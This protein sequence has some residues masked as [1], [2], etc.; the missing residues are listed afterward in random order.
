MKVDTGWLLTS[1]QTWS[2]ADTDEHRKEKGGKERK[3]KMKRQ[4][5]YGNKMQGYC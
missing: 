1:R 2:K 3:R 4:R 5:K